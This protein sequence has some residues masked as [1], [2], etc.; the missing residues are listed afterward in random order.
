LATSGCSSKSPIVVEKEYIEK[1]C[2]TPLPKPNF[3]KYKVIILEINGEEYYALPKADA[4][5]LVTNWV[6]YKN[7][8]ESNYILMKKE[9]V[10]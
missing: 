7:W 4:V 6:S 8:A 1:E 3:D 9:D 2:P 5:T 10:K